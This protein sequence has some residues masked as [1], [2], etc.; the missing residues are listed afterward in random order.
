MGLDPTGTVHSGAL[1]AVLVLMGAAASP[2]GRMGV[3]VAGAHP[4]SRTIRNAI[5]R[6]VAERG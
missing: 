6:A 1:V 3:D 4:T 2:A 5:E